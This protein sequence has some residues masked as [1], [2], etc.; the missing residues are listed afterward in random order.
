MKNK[1]KFLK[2]FFEPAFLDKIT[3]LKIFLH[4][5]NDV[6]LDRIIV[7]MFVPKITDYIAS[8]N[9]TL[10]FKYSATAL[11]L[12]LV[13]FFI[14][15]RYMYYWFF[16]MSVLFEKSLYKKYIPIILKIEPKF[17][18]L[19][20]TGYH[21]SK[22]NSGIKAIVSNTK[23]FLFNVPGIIV[24]FCISFY[25]LFS[26]S[27]QLGFLFILI[28]LSFVIIA[29]KVFMGEV[30]RVEPSVE[31]SNMVQGNVSRLIMSKNEIIFSGKI[32]DEVEKVLDQ[33]DKIFKI[34]KKA[35]RYSMAKLGAI[36]Y[37]PISMLLVILFFQTYG[38]VNL[39][40][41]EITL[42]I[43]LSNTVVDSMTSL[44]RIMGEIFENY[45]YMNNFIKM[46]DEPEIKNYENGKK[47]EHK[48]GEII[49]ENINFS[50]GENLQNKNETA[51][52]KSGIEIESNK[53]KNILQNF[54][55]KINGG[56]KVALVG[57]SGS[58]K[59]TIAK[60]ISGYMNPTSGKVFVDGQDLSVVSLKSYYKYIGY[61]T[62]EPMV[63]DG[64][65]RENLLFQSRLKR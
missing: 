55:L 11:L 16:A 3:A 18:E 42:L 39:S 48:N 45:N 60:L 52:E 2:R 53:Q 35:Y 61:L 37:F 56:E 12:F 46:V 27:L 28:M 29:S 5:L 4:G 20:G 36:W 49:L 34:E 57:K 51:E 40:V 43:L 41:G 38:L 14:R 32:Q 50:Y 10:A 9:M 30:A 8:G 22:F 54:N 47:F 64:S 65:I 31:I 62:Q 19:N 63:F 17:F 26:I 7:L 25:L 58:G 15:S 44:F 21:L 24:I 23:E 6:F 33:E 13:L 1:I 59:T